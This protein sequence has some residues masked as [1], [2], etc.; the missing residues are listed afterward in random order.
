M[1]AGV[2]FVPAHKLFLEP[3]KNAH[4]LAVTKALKTVWQK[5]PSVMLA[6][7]FMLILDS[8]SGHTTEDAKNRLSRPGT[9][10]EV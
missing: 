2:I 6:C 1:F 8:L 9:D 7:R 3:M 10:Q 5:R 4:F